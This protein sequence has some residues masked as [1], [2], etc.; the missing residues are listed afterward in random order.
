MA[1]KPYDEA[2]FQRMRVIESWRKYAD[3]LSWGKGQC[4]AILDDGCDLAV[5]QWQA[6]LPWGKKVIA[7]Y[8]VFERNDDPRPVP[9]G[10]HGTSVGYPSSLNHN[11]VWGVAYNNHVAQIRCIT[12]VHLRKDESKTLAEALQWV[13]DHHRHYNI[14]AVNLSP[15]DDNLHD[16]PEPTAIDVKLARLRELNIWVSAPCGNNGYTAGISWPAC[17][18]DCFAIGATKAQDDAVH[19]DRSAKTDI[20]VPAAAT[21]SSNAYIA[22]ASMVLREAIAKSGYD[23]R[24]DGPNLPVAM[25]RVFQKTGVDVYDPATNRHFKRLDLLAALDRVFGSAE[26][27]PSGSAP[28]AAVAQ[29]GDYSAPKELAPMLKIRWRLGPDY[30]M[31]IQDSAVGYLGGRIVSAG[32]FTRHPL[33]ILTIYPDAFGGQPSGFTKLSFALDPSH[34][35]LR[36]QRIADIP[37]PARQG[38]AVAVVGDAMYVMGGIN[39]S[40]P[41][42]YRDTCRLRYEQGKW[43]WT[44][45][46]T[47]RLPWPVYGAAAS[48]A[49]IGDKLYLFGAADFFQ[50]PGEKSQDFHTEA[51]R[52]GSPVSKALLVL[53][54]KD[55]ASGW[56]RLA[57]CPGLPQFDAGVAAAGGKIWRLGG[58][59]APVKKQTDLWRGENPYYN[60]VDSWV[61]DP[62]TDRWSRLRDMPDGSNRRALT[63]RDRYVILIAG[64]KYPRTWQLNGARTEAYSAAEKRK[65]WQEFFEK[66][67]LVYD[68][69]TGR[70]GTAD[71]LV[72]RTSYPSSAIVGDTIYCLGGEGGPRHWHPATLQIGT[73][74]GAVP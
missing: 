40:E 70:L 60:A 66:T 54:T 23:W 53:D 22:A 63:W 44:N 12:I 4:L 18:P 24:S 30:P 9:P 59:Y 3:K 25:M 21:S 29:S 47:C 31:G 73:I 64:Y 42:T 56:K 46:E 50:P 68:T 57:D 8:N 37:G 17:Q 43:T 14:T 6:L 62:A 15:V 45:L 11:G 1:Q 38:G 51:G 55:L 7:S 65:P 32:G 58:I 48:T 67:V 69:Q 19:C 71:P 52:D 26:G 74:I 10:Y 61:Y 49:V 27:T 33:G 28:T 16:K 72:E 34:E 13:V 5:P 41:Y 35:E 36:W 20:L 39:Y 2:D